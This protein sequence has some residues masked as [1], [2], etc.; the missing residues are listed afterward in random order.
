[1]PSSPRGA[2]EAMAGTPFVS[3]VEW[4]VTDLARATA[5]LEGLFGW[6][7]APYGTRYRLYTPAAG[8]TCVG[9]LQVA[10]VQ[11][12]TTT[13]VHV[14]V[15]DLDAALARALALGARPHVAPTAVPGHGRY[16]QVLDADGNVIGLFEAM[17]E[18]VG[19]RS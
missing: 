19:L 15:D 1:M 16:A 3:H 8:G 10:A 12:A 6:R 9:L 5:L 7:F 18:A 4:C 2:A 14:C 17:S 11:P 13:L